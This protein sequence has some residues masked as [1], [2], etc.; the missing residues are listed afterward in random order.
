MNILNALKGISGEYEVQR[1][2]GAAG[3]LSYIITAPAFLA[4]EIHRGGHFDLIAFCAAYPTGLG[5]AMGALAGAI[6]L[7]DRSVAAAKAATPQ[8]DPTVQP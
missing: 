2:V 6:S 7:K 4:W 8:A 5:V 1:V 3:V